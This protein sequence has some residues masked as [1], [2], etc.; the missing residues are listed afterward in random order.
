MYLASDWRCSYT[1]TGKSYGAI[2]DQFSHRKTNVADISWI[3]AKPISSFP[4]LCRRRRWPDPH[5]EVLQCNGGYSCIVRVNHREYYCENISE[6]EVLAREAA[7]QRAYQ[8]SVNESQFAKA[9]GVIVAPS[10][11][12]YASTPIM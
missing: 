3:H 5:Y 8:F 4:G 1:F 2:E 7:A 6:S 10:K 9:A 11:A 12:I